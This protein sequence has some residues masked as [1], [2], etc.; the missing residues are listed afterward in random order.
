[1]N[2]LISTA[3]GCLHTFTSHETLAQFGEVTTHPKKKD[4]HI[5]FLLAQ[6]SS[7]K[8]KRS[9]WHFRLIGW[10]KL[11]ALEMSWGFSVQLHYSHLY[12]GTEY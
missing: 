1:M 8:S 2:L 6:Y 3:A 12:V 10:Y 4:E 11:G 9:E 7:F 5:L